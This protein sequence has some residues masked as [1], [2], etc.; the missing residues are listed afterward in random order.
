M[1]INQTIILSN[2]LIYKKT[3]ANKKIQR[4]KNYNNIYKVQKQNSNSFNNNLAY[5]NRIQMHEF[6]CWKED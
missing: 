1:R 2:L 3:K 5:T 6:I 4:F